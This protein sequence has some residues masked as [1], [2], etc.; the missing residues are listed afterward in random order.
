MSK[1]VELIEMELWECD[2]CGRL[3]F[4]N[5]CPDCRYCD[6]PMDWV[7][8]SPVNEFEAIAQHFNRDTGFVCPGKDCRV[9]DISVR[10]AE[11]DKWNQS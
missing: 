1:R 6:V 11:F 10:R 9:H 3:E 7:P 4:A 5:D 8:K 2:E